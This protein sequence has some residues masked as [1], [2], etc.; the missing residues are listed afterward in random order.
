MQ[1]RVTL[2]EV[3]RERN[4]QELKRAKDMQNKNKAMKSNRRSVAIGLIL[5][6]SMCR[7]TG[8]KS[9]H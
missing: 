9:I 4:P 3:H 2:A 1:P 5:R 8:G 7:L 6:S